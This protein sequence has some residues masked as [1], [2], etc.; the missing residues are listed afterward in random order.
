MK[1]FEY[2]QI[3]NL[4]YIN[5]EVLKE[6]GKEGWE[7]VLIDTGSYIF[8]REMAPLPDPIPQEDDHEYDDYGMRV[9]R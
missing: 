9:K 4:G 1:L 6:L 5:K 8:K 3:A 7:L 2:K